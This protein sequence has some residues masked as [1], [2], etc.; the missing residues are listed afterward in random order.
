VLVD[1]VG[2]GGVSGVI[3]F[4]AVELNAVAK[5][6]KDENMKDLMEVRR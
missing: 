2:S 5:K 1:A 4:W 6:S 3:V